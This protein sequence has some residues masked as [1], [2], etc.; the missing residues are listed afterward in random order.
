MGQNDATTRC[1]STTYGVQLV[2]G[3]LG[4]V[5]LL[6]CHRYIL[7][8]LRRG[9]SAFDDASVDSHDGPHHEAGHSPRVLLRTQDNCRHHVS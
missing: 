4:R 7:S 8:R 5:G 6:L 3:Y 2:F 9:S 1:N